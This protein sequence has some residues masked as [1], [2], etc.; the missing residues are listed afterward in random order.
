MK[1]AVCFKV[2]PR[3][4]RVLPNDWNQFTPDQDIAYAGREFNCFDQSAL[5]LALRLK[6]ARGNKEPP[7]RCAAVTVGRRP[8]APF[9]QTL[10]AV[11]FDE[12]TVLEEEKAEFAP[13][14]VAHLL[15]SYIKEG[16]FDLVLAGSVAGM[17]DSGTVPF[18]LA[19]FLDWPVFTEVQELECGEQ[20]IAAIRQD[21]SG[22]WRYLLR[23]PL[24]L[25][26]GNSFAVLRAPTLKARLAAGKKSPRF[27]VLPKKEP[28]DS[29]ATLG[30]ERAWAERSCRMLPGSDAEELALL[31]FREKLLQIRREQ[32]GRTSP[33][34]YLSSAEKIISYEPQPAEGPIAHSAFWQLEKDW[35]E[36]RPDLALLPHT[37]EGRLL[38]TALAA[39]TG[40]ALFTEAKLLGRDK[41]K[42]I[43]QKRACAGNIYWRAALPL[44][45]ILT[46]HPL[47]E[48]V[49]RVPLMSP[50]VEQPRWLVEATRLEK[51]AETDLQNRPLTVICG[52]GISSAGACLQARRLAQKL[53]AG[54][55]LT[56]PAALE[57]WGKVDEIIGGSGMALSSKTCLVLGASG[58]GA[59][60]AG[61]E[62]VKNII[63]VNTDEEALIFKQADVGLLTDA[64]KLVEAMLG[65]LQKN[66]NLRNDR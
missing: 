19:Q 32:S 3:W 24:L 5:E 36:R 58:A 8:S 65:H 13:R 2:V 29:A 34:R 33:E 61:L 25:T 9:I 39:R 64:P 47:P 1:I 15:A 28:Q 17:A 59:F 12:V 22:R 14:S 49:P 55:G 43:V 7:I 62:G 44:P 16:R 10:F 50:T 20:G 41:G 18:W 11:G 60:M 46:L 40:A 4:E 27:P 37:P 31:L 26:V 66:N 35:R 23:P 57:S 21:R 51:P 30:F 52:L 56:R 54:F 38:A 53:G 6:E 63:A 45:V 48:G 42:L